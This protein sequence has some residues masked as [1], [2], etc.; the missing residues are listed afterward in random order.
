MQQ[1][2]ATRLSRKKYVR[3]L[4]ALQELELNGLLFIDYPNSKDTYYILHGQVVSFESENQ[5]KSYDNFESQL[6][7]PE[8][9]YTKEQIGAG[10]GGLRRKRVHFRFEEYPNLKCVDKSLLP[11][12]DLFTCLWAGAQKHYAQND[13]YGD[14]S[15]LP[16]ENLKLASNYSSLL[17]TNDNQTY[18]YIRE[19]LQNGIS[20]DGMHQKIS[21]RWPEFCSSG[22][23][24]R[25]LWLL[26][27]MN[28]LSESSPL[29]EKA[30]LEKSLK[31][32]PKGKDVTAEKAEGEKG[33][34]YNAVVSSEHRKRM[35]KDF[36]RF[37]GVKE[38][39]NYPDIDKAAKRL[40]KNYLKLEKS[41]KLNGES[42]RKIQELI[43]ATRLVHKTLIDPTSREEYNRR[44]AAGR[45]PLVENIKLAAPPK[46]NAQ[47][48]AKSKPQT[49]PPYRKLIME[50]NY[51]E[52]LKVLEFLRA[53]NSSDPEVLA[54]IGWVRWQL[55]GNQKDAEEYLSLS[56][57]FDPKNI[58]ALSYTADIAIATQDFEKARRYL[59]AL[60]R[61][62]PNN[63]LAKG[64]LAQLPSVNGEPKTSKGW[65][66]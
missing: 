32:K 30:F 64:K 44:K 23:L 46:S 62:Q 12:F 14:I 15:S 42:L 6:G 9:E 50:N 66:K 33:R 5:N 45:A 16:R 39:I 56:L 26:F 38:S 60:I 24:F 65:F 11:E 10:F 54:N 2:R 41:K 7:D 55:K 37:L 40:L 49:P 51:S 27:Q 57:T 29:E 52:A 58:E 36:Y 3:L 17:K 18:A 20:M 35:G 63:Q 1:D 25:L 8:L 21:A 61:L 4:L 47:K 48:K 34:D 43:Q 22:D 31:S 13:I 28:M 59:E 19:L 53:E